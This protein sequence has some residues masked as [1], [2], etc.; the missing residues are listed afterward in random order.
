MRRT[1]LNDEWSVR[2]KSDR[3]AARVGMA[4]E[5]V[6]VTLPHDAMIGTPRSAAAGAASGYYVGG[7]WEY[8]RTLDV[9]DEPDAVVVLEFEGV[10]RDAHVSVNGTIAAHRPYG[11]SNFFV[12]VDHLLRRDSENEVVV[13][14]RAGNDSRWY[15]GAGI[16][17]NVWL[18]SS[19]RVYL[20]PDGLQV[21]TPEID[22]D[23]AVLAVSAVVRNR[24][25]TTSQAT[26]RVEVIDA[27]GAAVVSTETPV[28]SFP[29]DA[30]AARTRLHIGTPRRWDFDD[31]YLY[32]CRAR[33][34]DGDDVLDEESTTFGIRTLALDPERGL[35]ISGEPV[36]LR[37]A[38]VHHD[39]G[40]IGAAT[41]DRAEERRVELLRAAGF[42][43]IRSAHHPMSK[44]M[45]AACDRIGMLV[46][47]ETFDMWLQTKSDDDYALRFAEWWEADVEAMVRKDVNHPSV[48]LYSIG[49]EVPDGSTPVGV[50]LARAQAAKVRALDDTRFVTQAVTGILIAGPE[51][52]D[53]IRDA[54]TATGVNEETEVNTAATNLGEIMGRAMLSSVVTARTVEA[55]SHLDVA[56]YNYMAT[57]FELDRDLFPQRVI[58][59]T[60][61]HP[62]SVDRDWAAVLHHPHVIGDF[63]WTGWDYL[64]EAGV[65]RTEYGE[66]Q[67]PLGMSAFLGE[68]PWRAAW[69]AD[70]DITGHRLPQ[71]YYREIV[72]GLRTDPYVAVRRPEHQG[73]TV[74]HQSPWAWNDVVSSWSWTGHEGARVTVEVYADADEVE[75]LLDGRSLARGPAGAAN[76]FR[77]EFETTYEPGVLEAVAWRDGKE[78]GRTS[79]R[80]AAGPVVLDARADRGEISADP[81][82]L[83]FVALTLVDEAGSLH[84]TVDRE[85]TVEV[86]GPG[87]AARSRQREPMHRGGIHR[88]FLPDVRRQSPRGRAPHRCGHHHA[89][90]NRRGMRTAVG[91][92]RCRALIE[93][94]RRK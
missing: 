91:P 80:S 22:D 39:N 38:C 11:Y 43:A 27:G 36:L 63:T 82:D 40:V 47:D 45:L 37:G 46:M 30:I 21:R 14:A 56:G 42:N 48:I 87:V 66:Q 64:G 6:P 7:N 9:P 94:V 44:A 73:R 20:P 33:L 90:R 59:S 24:S 85:I 2:P 77:T 86:D 81:K 15:S 3:F 69:C 84:N 62:P 67:S 71:S 93:A 8:R 12:P 1:P 76:R 92:H 79:L 10:Y 54:A 18:L 17:R 5:W 89:H 35:R 70:L 68:Y 50:Q 49:N 52:F 28:T 23:G 83:A 16:Y 58:V 55:F 31:P 88:T 75:L 32:I 53:E 26:L 74:V 13:D 29:G 51:L 65:G 34:L 4:P 78:V 61:S 60:E 25:A 72:F 57:R 41:I 19:G